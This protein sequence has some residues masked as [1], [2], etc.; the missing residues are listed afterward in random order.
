MQEQKK[1]GNMHRI[2]FLIS[3]ILKYVKCPAFM[4]AE[5][6]KCPPEIS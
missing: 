3:I 2:Q 6:E 1:Y 5:H 4:A